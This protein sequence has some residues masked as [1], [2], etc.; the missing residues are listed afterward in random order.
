[1]LH[2]STP[3]GAYVEAIRNEQTKVAEESPVLAPKKLDM[4]K[5]MSDTETATKSRTR[6]KNV[7]R[8]KTTPPENNFKVD[9][10]RKRKEKRHKMASSKSSF[11]TSTL[12]ISFF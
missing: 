11:E 2:N 1:M 6:N 7:L 10:K 9:N 4:Q 5:V 8:L 12:P 3:E